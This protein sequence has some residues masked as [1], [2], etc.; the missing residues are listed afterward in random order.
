[1][2]EPSTTYSRFISGVSPLTLRR[3]ANS[4][5]RRR[6]AGCERDEVG[7]EAQDHVGLV[8]AVLRLDRLAEGEDRAR[9]RV[10]A[11]GRLPAHPLRLRE[12]GEDAGHLRGEASA[13]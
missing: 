7:L 10:V 6:L 12:G 8:E 2:G 9:A 13:R 4:R 11:A 3:E 1:M 5:T